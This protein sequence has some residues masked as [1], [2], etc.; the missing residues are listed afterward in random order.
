[1]KRIYFLLSLLLLTAITAT[2]QNK[3]SINVKGQLTDSLQK[4]QVSGATVSLINAKDSSLVA[5]TRTDTAG[6]FWFDKLSA[7]SY[8]LSASQVNFH[9]QWKNFI[10][11]G[12]EA[13]VNLGR[14]SMKDK[15][16]ME[17]VTVTAQRP[18]VVVNGDTLEFNAEAFKTKPNAVVEDILKKM[19]GVEVD[20]D[21]TIRV[22]GKKINRVLVNGKDFFNGDPKMATRNLAADAL[23]KVQVFDKQSDQATFTGIDDG[24]AE[25]TINLK[26]KKD[27]KNAAFGKVSAAAGN[28]NRF[29]GQFN[30]NRFRGNQQLSAIGMANNTNRQGFSIMDMLNFSGQARKMMSGGGARIIINNDNPDEFGLPVAGINNNQGITKTIAGGFNYNDAWNKKTEANAS[31]LYNNLDLNNERNTNRQNILPGNNFTYR[32]NSK[33]SSKS[34]SSRLNF[35]ADSKIDSFNSIKLTSLVGYQKGKKAGQSDYESFVPGDKKLNNGFTN[36]AA[37]TEGYTT[38]NNLLFKHKFAKKG[39]TFSATAAMQYNDSRANGTQNSIS[40]FFSNGVINQ[41]DT[42]NQITKLNSI[43]QSYGGNISYTEPLSK[44]SLLE[45]RGFYNTNTGDLDRKT[46]DYNKVNGKHDAMNKILS[47]AFESRYNYMGGGLSMRAQQKKFSWSAGANVQYAILNSH[48]KDSAFSIRQHFTDVLP[49]AS[50]NYN[51]TRSKSVRIDYTTS[52]NQPTASQLQP[53]QNVS[54]PLNITTGNPSL[55]QEHTHNVSMQFF[56]ANMGKQKNLF[57]FVNYTA[58]QHAIVNSDVISNTGARTSMPVN[59]NAVHNI[60]VNVDR[61][62]RVKKLNTRFG[63]GANINYNRS[64]NFIN[65]AQNKTG[66][67]SLAPGVSANYSYKEL[68]DITAEA[69]GA[70]NQARY[71][72]QAA[73]NNNYWRQLYEIDATLNLKGGLSISSNVEYSAF[74]GRS[75]GY[76]THVTLWNASISKQILKSKKGE[77]KLSAFDLLN[78]NIGVDRNG[79]ANYVEDVQYKTLQRYFTAGF[80]YSLQKQVSGGPRAVIRTF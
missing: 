28:N 6:N 59:A 74:T 38:N 57:A 40:N 35:S 32:Q 44:R 46:Y 69:R 37:N 76:N 13:T 77:I 48:L 68:L 33:S 5:L 64:V 27:K 21:G 43:M 75:A 54:D 73:L 78:Q 23:D 19:P 67:L 24:N 55:Q 17:A 9:P 16:I 8:R 25:K 80:T 11:T 56:N 18:P 70:Y 2:A 45:L 30:I 79:N 66:N 36:T 14:I 53:V 50:F 63:L 49:L 72:L 71:S 15:S 41:R 20:K 26:L 39:R 42:L 34:E 47:N 3:K 10:L 65:G 60:N 58:T 22:N 51:I 29:D 1:M 61:G 62:F 7:G 4:Q 12:N 52:T 31:Y